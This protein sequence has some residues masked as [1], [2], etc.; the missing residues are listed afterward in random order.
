MMTTILNQTSDINIL[1]I[2]IGIGLTCSLGIY[3]IKSVWS[4]SNTHV[5]NEVQTIP[6]D[7]NLE[8]VNISSSVSE[9]TVTPRTSNFTQEQLSHIQNF[10][11]QEVQATDILSQEVQATDILS[12]YPDQGVQHTDILSKYTDQGVQADNFYLD[13]TQKVMLEI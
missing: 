13:I 1:F 4:N 7:A 3:L 8:R 2:G 5:D 11:N 6:E 10:S 12:K 9:S